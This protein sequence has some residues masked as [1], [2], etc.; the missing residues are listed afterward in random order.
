MQRALELAEQGRGQVSP[1]PMVGCVIVYKGVI[2]GEGYHHLYGG[3]HAEVNAINSVENPGQL[4]ES[5]CYVTL[6]PCSHFGHTPPCADLLVNKK[7]KRVVIAAMDTNP[8]VGGKGIAKLRNAGIDVFTGVLEK[9]ARELNRRFFTMIERRRPYV[10][11]KWAQTEDGFIARSNFDSKWIS[12]EQSRVLVHKWRAEEDAIMVGTNTARYDNPT[13][14]VRDWFGKNPLRVV[15]DKQLALPTSLKLFDGSIPTLVYNTVADKEEKNLVKIKLDEPY[16][17]TGILA[18]LYK[19]KVQSV[20]IEGG[21]GLLNTVI[22]SGLW[23]EARVFD[24]PV[25]F[26][27][28]IKAPSL[29]IVPIETIR[30]KT[31]NLKIYRNLGTETQPD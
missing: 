2:I 19:R 29:N 3:P 12:S 26:T 28:G 16:F 18:D 10:I 25:T 7:V 6:E 30:L 15:I 27:N 1:N 31:D 5:T 4:R 20:F 8:L 13:L 22:A 17:L 11:L 21:S 14:N 24:C 9:E 23:D